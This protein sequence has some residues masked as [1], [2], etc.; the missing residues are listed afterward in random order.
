VTFLE[1]PPIFWEAA[2]GAQVVDADGN[3]YLDLTGAFGVAVAGHAH[4]RVVAALEAQ[5]RRLVHGMGDVHPP[6]IKVRLLERLA[7]LAPWA[8]TRGFLANSGSEAVEAALKTALLATGRPGILAF[9]GS[10]HGLTLGSLATTARLAFRE[11][12][13]SH[14]HGGV[15]FAPF[16]D[17]LD[18]LA[19]P[20]EELARALDRVEEI[21]AGGGPE[22][23]P[24]GAVILEPIQG[25]GGVR[26][27]LP[28]FVAG[29]VERA[30]AAGAV[31]I[32]D[33]IFTGF[34]RTG[35]A[36]RPCLGAGGR[37]WAGGADLLCVG[38][39]LGG[40]LP[41]SACLGRR[42]VMDAWP[43][44]RGEALHTSTFLGHPLASPRRWPSST[45]W[46]RRSWRT[47]RRAR[48]PAC[49]NGSAGGLRGA[50]W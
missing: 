1:E 45:C 13:Q 9:E 35:R 42:E 18:G 17:A 41:L 19:A 27:P 12:F 24:V 5:A 10:Y 23:V 48:E 25:R 15:R 16:P 34:G 30:R 28:G 8:E 40:G 14:L 44:S 43:P 32:F 37:G 50:P 6:E 49:W 39:A 46:R 31:V 2:R 21:L 22:G 38:K 26:V 20:D 7:G 47:W 36:L 3:R 4:P 11:P 29:V 33:E